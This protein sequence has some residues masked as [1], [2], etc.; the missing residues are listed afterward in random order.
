MSKTCTCL[1]VCDEEACC[2]VLRTFDFFDKLRRTVRGTVMLN[3]ET[4]PSVLPVWVDELLSTSFNKSFLDAFVDYGS[5]DGLFVFNGRWK[6]TTTLTHSQICPLGSGAK[7][8]RGNSALAQQST[9][10]AGIWTRAPPLTSWI[11]SP[12]L[13]VGLFSSPANTNS[14]F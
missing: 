9:V 14:R 7:G 3:K 6:Y 13:P 8:E 5:N 4:V 11:L 12:L 2:D 10:R 1:C